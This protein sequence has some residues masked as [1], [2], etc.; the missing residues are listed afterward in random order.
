MYLKQHVYRVCNFTHTCSANKEVCDICSSK[1]NTTSLCLKGIMP[2]PYSSSEK[3]QRYSTVVWYPLILTQHREFDEKS[4]HQSPNK[5]K[6]ACPFIALI[7]ST[8][9][10]SM[11]A[12]DY[13]NMHWWLKIINFNNSSPCLSSN[14]AAAMCTVANLGRRLRA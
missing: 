7:T 6:I 3:I 14:S 10:S 9:V 8:S 4:V 1:R 11:V 2:Y 13:I 12:S 5:A